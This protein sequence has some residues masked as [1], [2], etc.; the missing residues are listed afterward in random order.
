MLIGEN[1][2]TGYII[3]G[4]LVIL[5][6]LCFFIFLAGLRHGRKLAESDYAEEKALKEKDAKDYEKAKQDIKQEVFGNANTQKAELSGHANAVDR[7]NA[8]NDKLS[9]KPKN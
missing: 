2:M 8:I 1:K 5:V 4:A 3:L 7:F 6:F 9:N